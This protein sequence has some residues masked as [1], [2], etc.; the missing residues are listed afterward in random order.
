MG[1]VPPS[2]GKKDLGAA[3]VDPQRQIFIKN[4][5]KS[6]THLDLYDQFSPFGEVVSAK[7]SITAN[8][9]SRCYG[10]VE[11]ATIEAARKAVR[12]MDNKEVQRR[13]GAP[14]SGSRSDGSDGENSQETITLQVTNFESKRQRIKQGQ[15]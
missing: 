7:I 3:G 9:E 8:F 4:C 13:D 6:W 10:F 12:E 15:E 2:G 14:P 5:P 11:F 1:T